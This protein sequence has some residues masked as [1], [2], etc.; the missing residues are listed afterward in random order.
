MKF[1]YF[2]VKDKRHSDKQGKKNL[3]IYKNYSKPKTE[4]A[5]KLIPTG[6]IGIVNLEQKIETS[7]TE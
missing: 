2:E 3:K 6:N 4:E 1:I 7:P 5:P